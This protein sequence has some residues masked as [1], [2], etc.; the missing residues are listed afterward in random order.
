M[1]DK[2]VS[3]EDAESLKKHATVENAQTAYE[4]A[5]WADK[6]AD[7]LGIDKTAVLKSAGSA[8]MSGLSFLA[9]ASKE[10]KK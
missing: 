2:G 1:Q 6:K 7:E 10:T 4:G 9:G 5:V 3:K 8:L